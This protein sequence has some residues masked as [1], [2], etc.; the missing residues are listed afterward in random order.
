M[1]NNSNLLDIILVRNDYKRMTSLLK[2]KVEYVAKRIFDKMEELDVDEPIAID[3][4]TIA[5]EN[6]TSNVG[7]YSYL[8]IYDNDGDRFMPFEYQ[9]KHSLFDIGKSFYYGNDF[10]AKVVG[11]TNKEAL[12]FLYAA[13]DFIIE[14]GKLEDMQVDN[15]T[16]ALEETKYI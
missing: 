16:D 8:A 4:V 9:T 2:D 7:D 6:V 3:G 5:R 11:A 1:E 14:L 12:A 13:K 10:E 15:I